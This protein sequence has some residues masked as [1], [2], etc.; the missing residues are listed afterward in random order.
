MWHRLALG[1]GMSVAEAKERISSREFGS[2]CAYYGIEPWGYEAD[3]LRCGIV[4]ATTINVNRTSR[5]GKPATPADFM[6][7]RRRRGPSSQQEIRAQLMG[8]AR[9]HTVAHGGGDT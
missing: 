9:A 3:Q 2:W 4:A 1:L 7:A 6:L 5:S 8:F